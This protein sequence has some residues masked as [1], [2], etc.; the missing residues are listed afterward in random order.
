M[1]IRISYRY[2]LS[3]SRSFE[4][5][6]PLAF[7]S[8]KNIKLRQPIVPTHKNF[9]VSPD[10]P[11][12][13]FFPNGNKSESC[14]RE[15]DEVDV[16]SR[17][18][19]FP[20]LRRKSFDDL[21]K[22]WYL[23]LKERNILAREVRLGEA[24]GSTNSQRHQDLDEKLILTQKRIKQVL[25]ERQV[26][27]ERA[28]TLTQEQQEYLVNFEAEYIQA[29]ESN[30]TEINEKLIRLQYALFGIEPQL[31]DYNLE[32]DINIKFVEGLSYI[33][34]LKA[35]RH[36]ELGGS[37][38]LPLNGPIEELPFLLRST[39][40]AID[41]VNTLRS[42]GKSIKLDKIQVFPFLKNAI[43]QAILEELPASNNV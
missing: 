8:L 16:E 17:P 2:L 10:H 43:R 36:V 3:S 9:D 12:W 38:E 35:K 11:L 4:R 5:T 30:I 24:I 25:L 42:E 32:Q 7:K 27:F 23:T 18:W 14:F 21:H 39:E 28:Q 41:E 20:E 15:A 19:N 6:K 34:N 31:Q 33:A 13:A 29:D 40:D 26:A 22:I 1:S 37:L